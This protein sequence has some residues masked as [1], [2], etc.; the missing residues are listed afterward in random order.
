MS[1]ITK[2]VHRQKRSDA[3]NSGH[4]STPATPARQPVRWLV[5]G[6]GNP[7][8]QYSATRHNVG[9]WAIDDLLRRHNNELHRVPGVEAF[10]A[11]IYSGEQAALL[12]RSAT[13]M[14]DSGV[15]VA[16]LVSADNVPA[17]HIVVIH[18]ELDLPVGKVKI[19]VGG[20]ENGHNGLK[21]LSSHLDTRDYVRIRVGI[22]RPTEGHSVIDHVL[23]PLAP[24]SPDREALERAA[25][26]AADAAELII[27]DG[28]TAAQNDIHRR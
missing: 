17:D 23:E 19:K 22:G 15:G 4:Q 11:T 2:L 5:I 26:T 16:P 24:H 25:V 18:D 27:T 7:G 8:T 9:Y 3:H 28:V 6:L 1:W 21:S 20:N 10:T 12:V 14:N 13:F